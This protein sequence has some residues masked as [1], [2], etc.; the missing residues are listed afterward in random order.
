MYGFGGLAIF[1]CWQFVFKMPIHVPFG[2]F[3][4]GN[5]SP[6]DVTYRSNPKKNRSWAKPRPSVCLSSVVGKAYAP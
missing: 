1:R 4:L 5:T 3:F 6:N 2:C